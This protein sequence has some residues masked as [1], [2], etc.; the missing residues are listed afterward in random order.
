MRKAKPVKL[1][2]IALFD[3][4]RAAGLASIAG[5]RGR[6]FDQTDPDVGI[7]A[8]LLLDYSSP[9]FS[10]QP[11]GCVVLADCVFDGLSVSQ[12]QG[13]VSLALGDAMEKAGRPLDKAVLAVAELDALA[14][15][16]ALPNARMV[17]LLPDHLK[18]AQPFG[19]GDQLFALLGS[20]E[21]YKRGD[22]IVTP[23][24]VPGHR[25]PLFSLPSYPLSAEA[26]ASAVEGRAT[27][28]TEEQLQEL[29]DLCNQ[30]SVTHHHES[31][32][33]IGPC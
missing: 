21:P 8:Q 16:V 27:D 19:V 12:Y 6:V 31:A 22:A 18:L 9:V 23:R 29:I 3:A 10:A 1:S 24:F 32:P 4:L 2:A 14:Q 15:L 33:S 13:I 26:F 25:R 30:P 7:R 11:D 5:A 20:V 17:L 28:F